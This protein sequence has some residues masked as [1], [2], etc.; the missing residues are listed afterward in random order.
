MKNIEYGVVPLSEI[1][2]GER[3]REDYGD[4][5]KLAAGIRNIGLLHPL[6]VRRADGHPNRF[7]V[8]VGGR[9]F[10][11]LQ[12]LNAQEIPVRLFETLSDDELREME[13]EENENRKDLT[14]PERQRTFLAS[15]R[16]VED[17]AKVKEVMRNS[18]TTVS[19]S[20]GGPKPKDELQKV[21]CRGCIGC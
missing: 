6:I 7:Q 11:A 10:K 4:I 19:K 9:R 20:K 1:E 18:R 5:E 8:V 12:L 14:Q 16:L 13:L 15:K 3:R 21:R 17:A 2:L